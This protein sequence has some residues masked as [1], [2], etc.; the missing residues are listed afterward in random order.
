MWC[1][2]L[3]IWER[4]LLRDKFLGCAYVSGSADNETSSIKS[5][6]VGK[7]QKREEK[8]PGELRLAVTTYDEPDAA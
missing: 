3:Q 6:L 1:H 7:G 2:I 5:P 4:R 8:Q